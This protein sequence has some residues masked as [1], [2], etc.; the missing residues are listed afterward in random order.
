MSV[1]A[2]APLAAQPADTA[3]AP[4]EPFFTRSDA[5]LAGGFVVTTLALA[6]LDGRLAHTLQDPDLQESAL[7]RRGAHLLEFMGEPAP[8]IIGLTLYGG[9]RLVGS[10]PVAALGLHGLEA[11][12]LSAG[13]TGA[14]KLTAGRARPYVRADPDP[15]DFGFLRGAGRDYASFPSGHTSTA[16]AVAASLA[17][18]TTHWVTLK[19]WWPGWK[20]VVGGTLFGGASL[21]GLSR[22]YHDQHWASD[23]VAGAAIGTFS[24]IKTVRYAYRNPDNRIDR[25][26]LPLSVVPGEGDAATFMW[27]VPVGY[28]PPR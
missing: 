8:M 27:I 1:L 13:I 7:L 24:G 20:Y 6:Q 26:L 4:G 17:A 11:L 14:I 10:R 25:W 23:V 3:T 18:E 9:G 2:C 15:N 5:V 16:F 12:L 21:V 22:M 19:S 28:R